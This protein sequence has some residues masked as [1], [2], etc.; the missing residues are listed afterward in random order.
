LNQSGRSIVVAD[1]G[2]LTDDMVRDLHDVIVS[3]CARLYG[4]RAAASKAAR[5]L[6]EVTK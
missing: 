3:M 1:P 6:A 2:E 4:K 5:A